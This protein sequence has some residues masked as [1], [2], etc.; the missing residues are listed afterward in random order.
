MTET[1]SV[2]VKL[3]KEHLIFHLNVLSLSSEEKLR[4]RLF[5]IKTE[6]QT[7]KKT[8][9]LH[10]A[11]LCEDEAAPIEK[12]TFDE[13]GKEI[14]TPVPAKEYFTEY[15][16]IKGRIAEY[17]VRGWLVSMQASVDFI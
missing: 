16:V 14:K 12:V 17:T 9:D 6:E 15:S 1:T 11:A 7:D 2:A 13:E 5:G 4:Q 3:G 10:V 8:Y